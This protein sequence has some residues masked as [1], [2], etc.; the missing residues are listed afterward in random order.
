VPID[1]PGKHHGRSHQKRNARKVAARQGT[2]PASGHSS[3]ATSGSAF[4]SRPRYSLPPP[5]PSDSRTSLPPSQNHPSNYHPSLCRPYASPQQLGFNVVDDSSSS[6]NLDQPLEDNTWAFSYN[7]HL[8]TP[9]FNQESAFAG[10][11]GFNPAIFQTPLPSHSPLA[12]AAQPVSSN[13]PILPRHGFYNGVWGQHDLPA[14]AQWGT[15]TGNHAH[16]ESFFQDPYN[17][18]APPEY[19]PHQYGTMTSLLG[20][21][22]TI[23]YPNPPSYHQQLLGR[24]RTRTPRLTHRQALRYGD[25]FR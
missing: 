23:T 24:R 25:L 9:G 14:F 20:H 15:Y 22:P 12:A 17:F 2:N 10:Q 18:Y 4:V 8:T 19:D 11:H 6:T 13:E 16:E 5:S 1:G 21:G 7:P 3:E